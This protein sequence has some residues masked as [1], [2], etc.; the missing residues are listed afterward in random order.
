MDRA[1]HG[2]HGKRRGRGI[3]DMASNRVV[4]IFWRRCVR[5]KK[6]LHEEPAQA[7]LAFH[8]WRTGVSAVYAKAPRVL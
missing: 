8:D 7:S 5:R 3:S 6:V 4:R 1:F 2:I